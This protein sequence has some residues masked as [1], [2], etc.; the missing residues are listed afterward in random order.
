MT[1]AVDIWIKSIRI[2]LIITQIVYIFFRK[3]KCFRSLQITEI[4]SLPM[5]SLCSFCEVLT[6]QSSTVYFDTQTRLDLS[7]PSGMCTCTR[8]LMAHSTMLYK[9]MQ[10]YIHWYTSPYPAYSPVVRS[11]QETCLPFPLLSE[12][13]QYIFHSLPSP[14]YTIFQLASFQQKYICTHA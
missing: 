9:Y 11:L 14:E 7:R 12:N 13:T 3:R 5:H 2:P 10:Q 4:R 1:D 8:G 6:I